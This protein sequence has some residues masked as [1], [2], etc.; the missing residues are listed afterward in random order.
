MN[1]FYTLIVILLVLSSWVHPVGAQDASTWM[2]D[3]NLRTAVRENLGLANGVALTQAKMLDLTSLHASRARIRNL[4][5]LEH[6][7]N[8]TY[9]VVCQR[10]VLSILSGA[11]LM[12][13]MQAVSYAAVCAVGDVLS[14]GRFLAARGERLPIPATAR[15]NL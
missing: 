12:S 3:A 9:Q 11:V 2:P 4:T 10:I 14:P 15:V 5:G 13:G 6:A 1:R 8:L 7:T